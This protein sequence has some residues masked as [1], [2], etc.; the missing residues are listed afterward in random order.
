MLPRLFLAEHSYLGIGWLE[1]KKLTVEIDCNL[2]QPSSA[3][4]CHAKLDETLSTLS[5]STSLVK[6]Y[7]SFKNLIQ[8][9]LLVLFVHFDEE[10]IFPVQE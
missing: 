8:I 2:K 6:A 4:Q 7:C 3:V 10:Y 5:V 1:K 9:F